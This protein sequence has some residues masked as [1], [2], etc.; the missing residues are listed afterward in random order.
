MSVTGE[1]MELISKT[2]GVDLFLFIGDEPTLKEFILK[3]IDAEKLG[4]IVI[5]SKFN[6]SKLL[7]DF[8]GKVISMSN[9]KDSPRV[10]YLFADFNE[11]SN[12]M[13]SEQ[14][15]YSKN[16]EWNSIFRSNCSKVIMYRYRGQPISAGFWKFSG[17]DESLRLKFLDICRFGKI[18]QSL[19]KPTYRHIGDKMIYNQKLSKEWTDDMTLFIHR[20]ISLLFE[21][22]FDTPEELDEFA[23]QYTTHDAMKVWVRGFTHVTQN[24]VYNYE[25]IEHL[26]DSGMDGFFVEYMHATYPRITNQEASSFKL[27]YM[28]AEFQQYFS[29]SLNLFDRLFKVSFLRPSTK[30]KTDILESFVG[31]LSIISRHIDNGLQFLSVSKLMWL[32][33]D[34]LSFDKDMIFGKSKQKVIQVN[35]SMDFDKS[36]LKISEKGEI[37]SE[38]RP[39]GLRYLIQMK[40]G[41]RLFDFYKKFDAKRKDESRDSGELKNT[42]CS[43][44]KLKV[45][46]SP[47]E[48]SVDEAEDALWRKVSDIYDAN[49]LTLANTKFRSNNIFNIVKI[50]A[51]NVY[52]AFIDK[53][54]DE[55]SFEEDPTPFI[56]FREDKFDNYIIMFMSAKTE[57]GGF[58]LKE[59]L[60]GIKLG[61]KMIDDYQIPFEGKIQ[62]SN[63]A[64][65]EFPRRSEE[66]GS[67]TLNPYELGKYKCILSYIA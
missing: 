9:F 6:N 62:Q 11:T 54:K 34:S 48:L 5:S 43:I 50:Q 41:D 16:V 35:E 44:V 36:M 61:Q 12:I 2:E 55:F 3:I 24:A 28:S 39:E 26:G 1:I 40:V 59:S 23:K 38:D 17:E 18:C 46:Y 42:L 52:S 7:T 37:G 13:G 45:E 53:I 60:T 15:S 66:L 4:R 47:Y 22:D 27:Q 63:L 21:G 10:A 25:P 57:N 30:A 64:V 51:S 58:F 33:G 49:N 14:L 56:Q 19:P 8:S 65:V 20:F 32:I 67:V 29:D 31:C